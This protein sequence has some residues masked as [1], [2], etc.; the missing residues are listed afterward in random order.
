MIVARTCLQI[1]DSS[2][3]TNI[4]ALTTNVQ[5]VAPFTSSA[6]ST[7][8]FDPSFPPADGYTFYSTPFNFTGVTPLSHTIQA[9]INGT[10]YSVW[11]SD[12]IPGQLQLVQ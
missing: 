2:T 1:K 6:I 3:T 9:T 5:R 8:E 7:L 11:V 10:A 12:G 4:T